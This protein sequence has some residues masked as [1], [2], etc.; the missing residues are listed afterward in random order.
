[1]SRLRFPAIGANETSAASFAPTLGDHRIEGL[2]VGLG[3]RAWTRGETLAACAAFGLF[4]LVA[5]SLWGQKG[6]FAVRRLAL[7]R[8]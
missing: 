4:A 6:V 8:V 7:I 1:M 5:A 2:G 3:V